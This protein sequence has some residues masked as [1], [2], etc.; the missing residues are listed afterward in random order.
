MIDR[1]RIDNSKSNATGNVIEIDYDDREMFRGSG[2]LKQIK[3]TTV[4]P[5]SPE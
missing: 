4:D 2:R 5:S 1:S 3:R